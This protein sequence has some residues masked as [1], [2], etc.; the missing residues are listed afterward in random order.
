[1]KILVDTCEQ[2]PLPFTRPIKMVRFGPPD[3]GDYSV[4]GL[5]KLLR[6]ERK[7]PGELWGCIGSKRDHF[8]DQLRRM[9]AFRYRILLV[10]GALSDLIPAKPCQSRLSWDVM[11]KN[12]FEW[13]TA[14]SVPIWF[15]GPRCPATCLAFE[16]LLVSIHRAHT[17]EYYY[18]EQWASLWRPSTV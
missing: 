8:K 10:E 11:C 6:V 14:C 12:L 17:Q 3:T 2:D 13:T 16:N 15:L 7:K 9:K 5:E 1:M 4:E 18:A